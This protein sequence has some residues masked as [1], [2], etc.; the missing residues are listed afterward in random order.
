M[1]YFPQKK[2][3]SNIFYDKKQFFRNFADTFVKVWCYYAY[4]I[5]MYNIK[6][7]QDNYV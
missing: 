1:L 2:L 5:L 4:N 6:Y 3:S 7:K